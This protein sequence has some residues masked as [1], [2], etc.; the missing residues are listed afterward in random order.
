[1][2]M[3]VKLLIER[4]ANLNSGILLKKTKSEALHRALTGNT[5]R[6]FLQS[7]Y[8]GTFENKAENLITILDKSV[9]KK[10]SKE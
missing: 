10:K 7:I 6:L 3:V 2:S 8:D 1:M 4:I 9:E 5:G